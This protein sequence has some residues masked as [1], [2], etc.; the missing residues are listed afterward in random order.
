MKME[1]HESEGLLSNIS[2]QERPA[3]RHLG[4]TGSEKFASKASEELHKARWG[5]T[6]P[7]TLRRGSESNRAKH[8]PSTRGGHRP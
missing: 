6:L 2:N 4:K 7:G 5:L 3:I 1:K 8:F